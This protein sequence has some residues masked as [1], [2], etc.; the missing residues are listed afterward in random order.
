MVR[1]LGLTSPAD[2]IEAYPWFFWDAVEPFVADAIEYL[3][4]PSEGRQWIANLN[5]HLFAV[6]HGRLAVGPHLGG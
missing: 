1:Q 5:S 3:N 2:L 6:E 4:L